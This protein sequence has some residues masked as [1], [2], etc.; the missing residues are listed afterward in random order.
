MQLNPS[1]VSQLLLWKILSLRMPVSLFERE[2][3]GS[4]RGVLKAY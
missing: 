1:Q 2:R 3:S 4:V